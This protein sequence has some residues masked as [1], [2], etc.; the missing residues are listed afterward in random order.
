MQNNLENKL[1]K[2]ANKNIILTRSLF[3]RSLGYIYLFAF[4]SLYVQIQGL[5]GDEGLLPVKT[6]LQKL[7]ENYKEKAAFYNFPTL[8]WFSEAINFY[9][10]N[11]LNFLHPT[12]FTSLVHFSSVEISL[13]VICLIGIIFSAGIAFNYSFA[14]HSAGFFICWIIY[15]SFFIV[16][17]VFMSFQWDIFLLETGFLAILLA[18][19]YQR[20]LYIITPFDNLIFNLLRFLMFRF[21]YSNGIIKVTANC[22]TWQSFTALHHHFQSQPLPNYFSYIAHFS[23]DGI[24]K[25]LTAYTFF[26]EIYVPILFFGF[27][28]RIKIFAGMLQFCLQASIIASGNYNFFNLLTM[29]VNLSLFDDE[30]LRSFIPQ[31]LITLFDLDPLEHE[32][33]NYLKEKNSKD[34]IN[35]Q[36][37]TLEEEQA[38]GVFTEQELTN[39]LKERKSLYSQYEEEEENIFKSNSIFLELYIFIVLLCLSIFFCFFYLYPLKNLLEGS[40]QLKNENIKWV[41]NNTII[42]YYMIFITLFIFLG[43]LYDNF[44]MMKDSLFDD[45][46]EDNTPTKKSFSVIS[47]LFSFVSHIFN[48]LKNLIIVVFLISYF[49]HV[50]S[51]FYTS[52]D[53]KLSDKNSKFVV[54]RYLNE[55]LAFSDMIFSRFRLAHGYGLFRRM[56]GVGGRPELEIYYMSE[57]DKTWETLNFQYK[58]NDSK[59][60]KMKFNIPHQPRIDWQIWFS[61]LARDI[62]SE[63]WLVIMLG[64]VLEKNP[65]TLDLLGYKTKQK[66]FFYECKIIFLINLVSFFE[67]FTSR[68]LGF[69]K[70][71]EI[72][73][74]IKAI[75]VEQYVYSFAVPSELQRT[76]R[77]WTKKYVKDFL[78]PINKDALSQIFEM[79]G[80]PKINE[81]RKIYISPFQNIPVIDIVILLQFITT[82]INFLQI[83]KKDRKG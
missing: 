17:Q 12:F 56:T 79:Y 39:I 26:I 64:K 11:H 61:A 24:K 48:L 43:F 3:L 77:L 38:K 46:V 63:P 47:K 52:L 55:G 31:F 71:S 14:L 37:K 21:I 42:N 15:L 30:I 40:L 53:L 9:I 62:N 74:T 4:L 18:P 13:Y 72:R 34:Y 57:E 22:P 7:T 10:A 60:F 44:N 41:F 66:G 23:P 6:L 2:S 32:H 51:V 75:K 36:N 82:F 81:K 27:P 54:D 65:V 68:F 50:I 58:M 59:E 8:L 83:L 1:K 69:E 80:I 70:K 19:K 73:K 29:V 20:T 76:K 5:W 45:M 33:I 28:R 35:K 25:M 49:L 67:M 16:G 78:P